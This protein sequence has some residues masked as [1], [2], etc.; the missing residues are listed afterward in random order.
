MLQCSQITVGITHIPL[1]QTPLQPGEEV[2]VLGYPT[3]LRALLGVTA[4]W[5][6]TPMV[7]VVGIV[8]VIYVY[9]ALNSW[10]GIESKDAYTAG[11]AYNDIL[12]AKE[13]QSSLG[14]ESAL[15]TEIQIDGDQRLIAQF[16][17]KA[18]QPLNALFVVADI[19]RPTHE[20]YDKE[21]VLVAQG[22]GLYGAPLDLALKGIWDVT[23]RAEKDDKQF[24]AKSRIVID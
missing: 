17:D 21:V 9:F 11:L 10:S 7:I 16:V 24:T 19:R 12:E 14:W 8:N 18:G 22:Q 4:K 5:L 23:L 2:I 3:G 20:G 15:R 1:S 6:L 13:A